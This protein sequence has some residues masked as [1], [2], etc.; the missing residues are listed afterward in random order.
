MKN[1]PPKRFDLL[2]LAIGALVISI[3]TLL[4]TGQGLSSE[5]ATVEPSEPIRITADRLVADSKTD[6]AR[7]SG[8]VRAVQG[9]TVMTADQLTLYYQS[10]NG[11]SSDEGPDTIKRIMAQGHVRIAFDNRL[12]VSEQAVYIMAERKLILEGPGSKMISGRDEIIGSKITF[13][14]DDGRVAMEGDGQNPVKAILHSNQR[15]LN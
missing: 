11:P 13:F 14:R 12:A 4:G 6:S 10:D 1:H 9:D 5:P 2:S 7:F 8:N 3:C 15:G